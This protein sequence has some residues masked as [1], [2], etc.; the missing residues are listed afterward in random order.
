MNKFFKHPFFTN[1]K[2]VLTIWLVITIIS[3]VK[4]F[5][6]G[7]YN[8]YKIFKGVYFHTINKL[9]LYAEYPSEYFDHNHYGPVFSLIIAPF[10]ILPDYIGMVLWGV[11]N[12]VILVWAITQLP[13]KQIQITAILW[14]CLHEFLTALLGLQFNPLMTAIIILSFVY[15][16]KEKVFWAAM[17]IVLGIFVKLYGIVGLAFF[18]FTK[19][20]IKFIASLVFWSVVLFALP[21]LISSPEYIIQTYIEWFD[22]LVVK[23][24]EN[25]GLNSYQDICLMGMVRRIMQDSTISNLPFLL[26]GIVLFGLQYLRI[27]QYKEKGFRLM[28]LA[29]VLIFTVIFSTG[30]ESPTYIIAF[31]G[32]AIWFV[33][34]PKPI[35]KFYI[36]LF[37]FA[38]ILTSLSPSDLMPKF[39][40][41]N[42]IRP[43]AL[44]ALPCVLIWI[45][46]IYEMLTKK[47]NNYNTLSD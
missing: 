1:K 5:L 7:N 9:S 17:F 4:Q 35:S 22:R 19:D 46:I 13:L 29:S 2:Y 8:N 45:A 20:K 10:A 43:F 6:I 24:T 33:I 31:V 28:M 3:A 44:K 11:F 12:A 41:E 32:V 27:K 15:I 18:F 47:F 40:R 26:S 34:Q 42:Y 37:I 23:N 16:D 21:M 14:I 30:S 25:T 38:I 36:F 39:L